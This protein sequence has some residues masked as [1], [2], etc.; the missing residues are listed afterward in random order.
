MEEMQAEALQS[1]GNVEVD[2]MMQERAA[3][4]D[5]V[6]EFV[7][8]ATTG[9]RC[10][11]IDLSTGGM[12]NSEYSLDQSLTHLSVSLENGNAFSCGLQ[13]VREVHL[14]DELGIQLPALDRFSEAERSRAILV[15]VEGPDGDQ[16][17]LCLLEATME[18]AERF[19]TCIEILRLYAADVHGAQSSNSQDAL[20]MR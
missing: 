2:V 16:Q 8:V 9:V 15:Q 3:L 6:K 14:Y 13:K 17:W 1:D 20:E 4:Q 12:A 19:L 10:V 11:Y 5:L 7:S 18:A